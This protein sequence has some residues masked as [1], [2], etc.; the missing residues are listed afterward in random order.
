M[1]TNTSSNYNCKQSELYTICN[2]GW[3]SCSANLAAF[4]ALSGVYTPAY[5]IAKKA[6]I[7]AAANLPNFQARN[8]IAETLRLALLA[9][10]T[11]VLNIFQ[12]LKLHISVALPA[13]QWQIAYDAAGWADYPAAS[14]GN[15]DSTAFMLINMNNYVATNSAA[16]L[17]NA[18]M[19]A[20]FAATLTAL[21]ASFTANHYAFVQAE[22]AAAVATEIKLVANN[23]IHTDLM[24]MFSAARLLGFSTAVMKQ[25]TFSSL[26]QLISGIGVSGITGFVISAA[27]G[28]PIENASLKIHSLGIHVFSNSDGSYTLSSIPSGN[29][30]IE[31][32]APNPTFGPPYI[33]QNLPITVNPGTMSALDFSMLQ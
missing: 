12:R 14:R 31:V 6:A 18:N 13:N 21:T 28:D 23:E 7:T 33:V 19:P 32:S 30:T 5:V 26:L 24:R 15:W 22:E 8:A 17:A 25:F 11:Q 10:N 20:N 16:L 29:Y 2:L 9:D 4:T 3:D 1:A 27:T